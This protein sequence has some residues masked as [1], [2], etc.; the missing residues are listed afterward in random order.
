MISPAVIIMC[1]KILDSLGCNFCDEK[2]QVFRSCVN[3][4]GRAFDCGV[5]CH[6]GYD[7]I[8]MIIT[9]CDN[10]TDVSFICGWCVS[11]VTIDYCEGNEDLTYTYRVHPTSINM[12]Y[13]KGCLKYPSSIID[14]MIYTLVDTKI[15]NVAEDCGLCG[16]KDMNGNIVVIFSVY[17]L[18]KMDHT[19]VVYPGSNKRVRYN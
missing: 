16:Y 4:V 13:I 6:N 7:D 18:D 12:E 19:T 11:Y 9:K 14:L 3:E 15:P 5:I 17:E 2:A 1:Y 10:P 8:G